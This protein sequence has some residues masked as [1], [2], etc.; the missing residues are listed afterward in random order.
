MI[1]PIKKLSIVAGGT[2][3]EEFLADIS[4]SDYRIGVDRGAY[5]LLQRGIVPDIAIGDFDSISESEF[6]TIKAKI[7]KVQCHPSE[8]DTTDLELAVRFA[9][10]LG[11]KYVSVFGALGT[12]MDHTLSG[13]YL[14][15]LFHKNGIAA[16]LHDVHNELRFI[17][18]THH[19]IRD[20]R[21]VYVSLI[22]YTNKARVTLRGFMYD[23]TNTIF[24]RNSSLGM[25]NEL[26]NQNGTIVVHEGALI[27]VRSKDA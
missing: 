10:S 27:L 5:W 15:E 7:P 3:S 1:K 11:P 2:L 17:D 23:V 9:I 20:N 26:V 14:L 8:K 16:V 6:E 18:A 4:R 21:F 13:M 24:L 25:S 12:R 22:P 19:I